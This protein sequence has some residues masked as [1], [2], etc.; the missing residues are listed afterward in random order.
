M[1]GTSGSGRGRSG[2]RDRLV[3]LVPEGQPQQP[4]PRQASWAARG[5]GS[6]PTGIPA[7]ISS[8]PCLPCPG[9]YGPPRPPARRFA[10]RPARAPAVRPPARS[11]SGGR[12][13]RPRPGRSPA[14]RQGGSTALCARVSTARTVHTTVNPWPVWGNTAG[15]CLT[16]IPDHASHFVMPRT[17]AALSTSRTPAHLRDDPGAGKQRIARPPPLPV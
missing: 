13:A 16:P 11:V 2:V 17:D 14:D 7:V 15:R 1:T 12:R 5:N 8:N 6:V 10:G 9:R 4:S 3:R